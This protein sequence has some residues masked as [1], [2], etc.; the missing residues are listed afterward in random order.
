MKNIFILS[1]LFSSLISS[2]QIIGISKSYFDLTNE[3][4]LQRSIDSLAFLS[5]KDAD[6]LA[7]VKKDAT[8]RTLKSKAYTSLNGAT[9]GATLTAN[10]LQAVAWISLWNTG[11]INTNTNKIDSTLNYIK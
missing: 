2:A 1:F 3:E 9:I 5:Q 4:R 11:A 7:Q 6:F 8:I 10:Q